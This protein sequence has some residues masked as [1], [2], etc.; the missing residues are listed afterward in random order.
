MFIILQG[1]TSRQNK[2][3]YESNL[4]SLFKRPCLENT[5]GAAMFAGTFHMK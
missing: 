2:K 5:E 4:D 1:Q 3:K